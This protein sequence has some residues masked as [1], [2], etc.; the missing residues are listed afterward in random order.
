MTSSDSH[1]PPSSGTI[2]CAD[3]GELQA[4]ARTATELKAM[5]VAADTESSVVKQFT[6]FES[7]LIR[8]AHLELFNDILWS[9]PA[10][11]SVRKSEGFSPNTGRGVGIYYGE[12]MVQVCCRWTDWQNVP[13]CCSREIVRVGEMTVK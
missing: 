13:L 10:E 6:E 2:Y 12:P 5:L 8:A 9:D 1:W 7:K 4:A 3:A 11:E